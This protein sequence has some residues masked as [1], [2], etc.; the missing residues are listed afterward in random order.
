MPRNSIIVLLN[1]FANEP[2][3]GKNEN[4]LQY[5]KQFKESK[6]KL[7]ELFQVVLVVP[8]IQLCLENSIFSRSDSTLTET[9]SLSLTPRMSKQIDINSIYIDKRHAPTKLLE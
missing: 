7:Y 1:S 4:V 5:S 3:L 2:K 9:F 8:V 6:R